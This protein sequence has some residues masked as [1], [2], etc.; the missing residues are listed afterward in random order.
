MSDTDTELIFE[1]PPA[2]AAGNSKP[3]G[4]SPLGRWLHSLRSHPGQW[5]KFPT[6][7]RKE[8]MRSKGYQARTGRNYGVRAGEFEVVT[9]K[10]G[11]EVFLYARYVGG[12]S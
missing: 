5:A 4:G 9:R 12:E 1:E 3:A 8:A 7:G 10:V 2:A 6:G 11:D